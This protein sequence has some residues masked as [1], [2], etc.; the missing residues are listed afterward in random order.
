MIGGIRNVILFTNGSLL[1]PPPSI[2]TRLGKGGGGGC[3]GLW[4]GG[5]GVKLP[6][7]QRSFFIK[8]EKYEPL[9]KVKGVI[10]T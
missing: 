6:E 1:P 10:R 7:P 2:R 8:P 9:S 3:W 4:W 5:W